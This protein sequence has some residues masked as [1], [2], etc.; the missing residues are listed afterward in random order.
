MSV[1]LPAPKEV[2]LVPERTVTTPAKTKTIAEFN[3]Q[4]TSDFPNDKKVYVFTEELG[5]ILLWEGIEY[6]AIGQ[7]TDDDVENRLIELYS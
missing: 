5:R 3:I 6:D 1:I 7:W 4:Y 2:I